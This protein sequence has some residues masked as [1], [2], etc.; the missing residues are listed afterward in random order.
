V[1]QSL[2]VAA[3]IAGGLALLLVG[4]VGLLAG[5]TLVAMG[6][7]G[8]IVGMHG[9]P[10]SALLTA[11]LGLDPAG[12]GSLLARTGWLVRSGRNTPTPP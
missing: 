4:S 7:S 10:L 9:G 1:S 3:M 11:V 6:L 8:R 5:G 12:L 2:G